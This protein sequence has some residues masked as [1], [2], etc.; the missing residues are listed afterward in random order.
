MFKMYKDGKEVNVDRDQLSIMKNAGWSL[1]APATKDQDAEP[2]Q[3][4]NEGEQESAP[5]GSVDETV[6]P[7]GEPVEATPTRRT[8]RKRSSK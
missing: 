6:P 2:E 7:M 3:P 5:E 1:T 4:Q 8:V